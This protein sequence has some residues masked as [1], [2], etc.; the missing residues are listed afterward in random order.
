MFRRPRRPD[1]M[2]IADIRTVDRGELGEENRH[3][4]YEGMAHLPEHLTP[5]LC[6]S[7]RGREPIDAY[8]NQRGD[9][10]IRLPSSEVVVLDGRTPDVV[11]VGP[12]QIDAPIPEVP[13]EVRARYTGRAARDQDTGRGAFPR[14]Y[15]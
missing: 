13:E 5:S 10:V 2:C 12:F 7:F 14:G 11:L 3:E 15:E 8:F 1:T 9:I 4:G 6:Y